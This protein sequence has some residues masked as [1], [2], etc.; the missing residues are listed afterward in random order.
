MNK[1]II[2]GVVGGLIIGFGAGY[3]VPHGAAPVGGVGQGQFSRMGGAGG[4]GFGGGAVIGQILSAD[5]TS[6]TVKSA[7]GSSKIVLVSGSTQIM[8]SAAGTLKDLSVGTNVVVAGSA[9]SDGSVTAQSVQI[10]PAGMLF[11]GRTATTT[12]Q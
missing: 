3:L 6:I 11:G 12:G 1:N 2:I 5:A 4:R 7:D 10:R 9:N 8:K